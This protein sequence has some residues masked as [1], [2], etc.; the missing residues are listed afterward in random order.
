MKK[1][2]IFVM[3]N[4]NCGGAENALV[5]LL[6]VLDFDKYN[7]DLLLF[8][9]EGIF[10]DKLPSKV[11]LLESPIEFRFF[12][13]PLK[14][15]VFTSIKMLR[16][17]ILFARIA[18]IY[19][20]KSEKI[21]TVRAQKLWKYLT[22][23]LKT[24]PKKYDAAIGYLENLPNFY[25]VEKIHA[26]KKIGF[27]RN[28]YNKLQLNPDLDRP[29]FKKLTALLTVSEECANILKNTFND[30]PITIGAMHSVFS[31]RTINLMAE[32]ENLEL[33][34]EGISIVSLGRLSPQ[35]RFDLAIEAC[36]IL[37]KKGINIKWYVLG[38]GAMK[39]ELED[40]IKHLG[41]ENNFFL[42]GL[43]ENPYP[44]I[45]NASAY[46][47]TSIFEGR[48]RAIEEAKILKKNIIVTNFPTVKDQI[49]HKE[50][51]FIVDINSES[52]AHGIQEVMS[53]ENLKLHMSHVLQNLKIDN[54]KELRVL[55]NIIES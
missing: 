33:N 38:D 19:S 23:T 48:S 6:Q 54:D 29:Y 10:L 44:Y 24:Q 20:V 45:K 9:K 52:I 32:E 47:Q 34:N 12:D 53:N 42:L 15:A 43:K 26:N 1:N 51:G 17:D 13:M 28:D 49:T 25:V 37:V 35:K 41:L 46:V 40:L 36:S 30:L 3:N 31:E 8:K 55:Y 14:K 39:K 22:L 7:V 27:I 50:N 5:S 21:D 18:S 4:L 11:N 16:F 2:L